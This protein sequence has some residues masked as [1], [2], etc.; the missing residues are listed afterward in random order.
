MLRSTGLLAVVLSLAAC[1]SDEDP[2]AA[3]ADAGPSRAD[4]AATSS[5]GAVGLDATASPSPA[6]AAPAICAPTPARL[7]VLGDSITACSVIGGP[8]AADCVSKQFFDELKTRHPDLTYENRAV[9]GAVLS[10]LAGQLAGVPVKPGHV[11]LMVYIGGNDLSPYIFVSDAQAQASYE[12]V[13]GRLD[14]A[15]ANVFAA[16]ADP[17]KFPDGATVVINNQYN[18]FDDCDADPY[19]LSELKSGLLHDFN[20]R[21]AEIAAGHGDRAVVV[22]QY[23]PYLGHGHHYKVATCPYYDAS[24]TGFMKDLIHPNVAG[25]KQLAGELSGAIERLYGACE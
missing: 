8:N 13:K 9:G 15:W 4:A 22:D 17:S 18:P 11:L 10:N 7:V 3:G 19:F 14:A 16:I 1:G 2:F 24:A 6:D 5:D 23:T 12:A 21:V 20:A 25:N